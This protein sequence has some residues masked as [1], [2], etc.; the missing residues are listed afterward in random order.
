MNCLRPL[1]FLAFFC[2]CSFTLHAQLETEEDQ[3]SYHASIQTIGVLTT[4]DR[5]P[6]WLRSNQFGSV[7]LPGV[8]ASLIGAFR[9]VYD[10]L[11]NL[12]EDPISGSHTR[13]VDWGAAL[14]IRGD[15][16]QHSRA[17]LIEGYAKLKVSI[18]ELK[19]GRSRDFM[20]LV[21]SSLSSGA[22]SVSGNA[23]GIPKI[24]LSIP[25]YWTL[26]YTGNL[27]SVKGNFVHGW[28]G[29][30]PVRN[31]ASS[32]TFDVSTYF[33]QTSLYVRL[34]KPEWRLQLYGG[35]NHQ[36]FWGNEKEFTGKSFQLSNFKSFEYA[37][38]G[39]TYHGS[40]VGN[41][42]GSIDL[43]LEYEFETV[44]L[45]LYRQSFYDEGALAKLAN[46]A[47]GL[48]GVSLVNL[49][50]DDQDGGF[51]WHRLLFELFYSKNQAGYPDSKY[52]KSGDENYYNNYQYSTGWSYKGMGLGNPFVTEASMSRAG[53][54]NDP[55]NY[56][57][58]NRVVALH[59]GME[60]SV[61]AYQFTVKT[62]YSFNY[63]TFGTSKWGYSTGG[64][65]HPPDYGI[66]KEVRQLS[67]YLEVQRSVGRGWQAGCVAALDA[68]DLLYNSSGVLLKLKKSF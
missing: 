67:T 57:S 68:G 2:I 56:F 35:L 32:P 21:D 17:T 45:L 52:T 34:G 4:K 64:R 38:L 3:S 12:P 23:L 24:Q 58:N 39:K 55:S 6:F 26:P 47:D 27:F 51:H 25:E 53:L 5:V 29:K 10:T 42:L 46:I 20:G 50:Q 30:L 61:D 40:K 37:V 43:G 41:H 22:F 31:T 16:G 59:A 7:P 60:G 63:G 19:A 13:L 9:K 62:S 14:E 66:W 18:F 36:V 44:K 28:L 8:S 54:P 11:D 48:N 15:L 33:H 1:F 65:F 49:N